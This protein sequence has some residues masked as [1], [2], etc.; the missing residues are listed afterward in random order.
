MSAGGSSESRETVKPYIT[1]GDIEP[2]TPT[3]RMLKLRPLANHI[4]E[5]MGWEPA[6]VQ[7]RIARSLPEITAMMK[8]GLVDLYI[9]SSYPVLLV[10]EGSGAE[11]VMESPVEASRTYNSV[12]I[13]S[14]DSEVRRLEDL[15]GRIVG[16][17]E[18]Y[19][20]SGYLLPAAHLIQAGFELEY[21]SGRS[22][23]EPGRVGFF[24]PGD[25]ENSLSMLQQ[26]VIDAGAMSGLDWARLPDE[27]RNEFVVLVTTDSVPRKML[28]VRQGFDRSLL[29][30]LRQA[31]LSITDE[32]RRNMVRKTGWSWEFM[33]LDA[34]SMEGIARTRQM[35]ESTREVMIR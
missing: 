24:F 32:Q 4:A 10:C 20:T 33:D 15:R 13:A 19:S 26:G 34:Q 1:I 27:I 25:E 30:P 35:I 29:E 7:V 14:V 28:A 31:L 6:R 18:F 17:Q 9:D 23:P 5:S 11:V 22:E 2:D 3:D 8:D 12:I 21:T 16:L